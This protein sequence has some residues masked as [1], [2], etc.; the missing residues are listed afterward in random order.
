[1]I[2]SDTRL[3]RERLDAIAAIEAFATGDQAAYISTLAS[4]NP[5]RLAHALAYAGATLLGDLA[6][7]GPDDPEGN[8]RATEYCAELRERAK[9]GLDIDPTKEE[10]Q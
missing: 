6:D 2:N 9:T 1:V 7:I 3:Y 4:T 8:T 5:N 10:D